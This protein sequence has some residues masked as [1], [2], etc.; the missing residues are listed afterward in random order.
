MKIVQITP[1]SG[2]N[3]YCENCLR[4]QALV[5]T[6]RSQGH[7]V[8][9]VPLYLPLQNESPETLTEAPIFFGGVNV[10]LQQKLGL[11]RRTPRWL[12]KL[13]DNRMLLS[14]VSRK[15]GVTSARDLGEATLSMLK[16]EHGRQVKEL[17]RLVEWL[18][19]DTERPDVIILSN[20]LLS[21]LAAALRQRLKVPVV[22][23][24][25]DEEGFVDS[26]GERYTEK[27]WELLRINCREI[28]AFVS[29]SRAYGI[30]IS[31]K[32]GLDESRLYTLHMGLDMKNYQPAGSPPDRPTIGFLSRMCPKRGLDKLVDAFILLKQAPGLQSCQL[33][34]TGGKSRADEPFLSGIHRRLIMAGVVGDVIFMPEFLGEARQGWLRGLTLMCVP[35]QEEAAYGLFAMEALATAVP[36]V[37][38]AIGIFPE[39]IALTGGGVLVKENSPQSFAAAL[40]PLLL[41]PDAA[42]KLGQQ[43]R[44]GMKAH[45][46]I[47]KTAADLIALLEKVIGVA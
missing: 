26:L 16:G 33:Q 29:V 7:D 20:V 24:L 5:K 18:A 2:D 9:M 23:L 13:F 27:A 46:D 3:F 22:C 14:W 28:S 17:D 44:M 4:D 39:L 47:E 37:L 34:V 25:Q 10:Y 36:V 11:F 1:G 40:K 6:L 38:P 31:P 30:R 19:R 8:L 42:R 41:G 15:A 21:G 32:L 43:G 12:D 35:E 45:F